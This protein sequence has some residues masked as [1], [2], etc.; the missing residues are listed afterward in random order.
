MFEEFDGKSVEFLVVFYDGDR[1]TDVVSVGN[2]T[3]NPLLDFKQFQKMLKETIGISYNNLT[4]Y[5]IDNNSSPDRRK[6]LITGKVNFAVIAL[7][8]NYFF[9]V[10]LKQ[11]RRDRRRKPNNNNNNILINKQALFV[12]IVPIVKTDYLYLNLT[13]FDLINSYGYG[14]GYGYGYD[15]RLMDLEAMK[16]NYINSVFNGSYLPVNASFATVEEAYD[17]GRSR[18]K[19]CMRAERQGSKAA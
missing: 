18:C 10:V 19:E 1:Q 4:T 14:Y 17:S 2:I 16:Q 5:L 7:E 6:I 12:P 3:I 11:S 9:L 8:Q 15:D 13:D